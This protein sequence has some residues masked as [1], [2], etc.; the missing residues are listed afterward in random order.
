[1]SRT[2]LRSAEMLIEQQ[3]RAAGLA[4]AAIGE[5]DAVGLDE[6]GWRSL[7]IVLGH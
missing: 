5:M 2:S 7:V 6:L 3:R 1:M 4:E